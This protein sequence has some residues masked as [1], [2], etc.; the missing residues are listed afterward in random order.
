MRKTVRVLCL[1]TAVSLVV[2]PSA[3]EHCGWLKENSG[4]QL[5][6]TCSAIFPAL[7]P[8]LDL[9][10]VIALRSF[11][12]LALLC[13]PV[14]VMALFKGRWFCR[15]ICPVGLITEQVVRL[16][17]HSLPAVKPL[18]FIHRHLFCLMLG[19][20]LIG[21]P[22]F[23]WFDPL[24][25]FNGF[26]NAW[27]R[28]VTWT[29]VISGMGFAVIIVM[30]YIY[31]ANLCYRICP[32]GYF[33]D[34][35]RELARLVTKSVLHLRG[36]LAGLRPAQSA[37]LSAKRAAEQ[38]VADTK[39]GAAFSRF[40]FLSLALGGGI[41]Y[42]M[43]MVNRKKRK[44]IRPPGA[45]EESS[46]TALCVRCGNCVNNCPARVLHPDWTGESGL[47]GVLTPVLK[48]EP[49][50]CY[51]WC[52]DCAKVC[53]TGAI[54]RISLEEKKNI[55]FG[56]AEVLRDKCVAW[57]SQQYCKVCQE[58]CPYRAIDLI[59]NRGVPCPVVREDRC[60]GC[61][62]CQ[63]LCPAPVKSIIVRGCEHR[64]LADVKTGRIAAL[65]GIYPCRLVRQVNKTVVYST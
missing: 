29:S 58:N 23:L 55:A 56:T 62:I 27:H 19:S 30:S 63:K 49:D 13:L 36:G 38:G 7:S 21:Y 34:L 10:S 26:L 22:L 37:G 12:W 16:R 50:Y 5:D 40:Q 28:P 33:Q 45:I 47:E 59:R 51:E 14:L 32:L 43:I 9:F 60:R 4:F 65:P 24:S 17:P 8:V 39:L 46:F 48:V 61:G 25:V 41:G 52:N 42:L 3:L 35:M 18:P 54:K 64:V 6:K 53:P 1:I 57:G 31:P 20:A 44:H 11:R 15:F 2:L